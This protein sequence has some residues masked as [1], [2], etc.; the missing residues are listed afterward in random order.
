MKKLSLM[1]ISALFVLVACN[2]E[3]QQE[4]F[5][6]ITLKS[7]LNDAG[8]NEFYNSVTIDGVTKF[9]DMLWFKDQ[10]SFL[11]AIEILD[12]FQEKDIEIFN[13]KYVT[14]TEEQLENY[15]WEEFED[16]ILEI[17][18]KEI[19]IGFSDVGIFKQ[20]EQAL[21]F[22]SLRKKMFDLEYQFLNSQDENWD[23]YPE[24]E[25][26]PFESEQTVFNVYE[27]VRIGN[28]I[29]K[30]IEE[31]Y[32]IIKDGDY[33]TLLKLRNNISSGYSL[34]NV[35]FVSNSGE[36]TGKTESNDCRAGKHKSEK[37]SL[38]GNSNV[39]IKWKLGVTTLP[40]LR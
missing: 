30:L 13:S 19:E 9:N 3:N 5:R 10:E 11:K 22:N 6:S 27:E 20:F 37:V 32:F 31:G 17:E 16:Y 29:Y 18:K 2:K 15:S 33:A 14:K 21:N 25:F 36:L 28:E 39:K 24:H 7:Q 40:N 4:S 12:E 34:E 1:M 38:S 23:N 26:I 35:K 8:K